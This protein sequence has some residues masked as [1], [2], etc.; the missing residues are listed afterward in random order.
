MLSRGKGKS[1]SVG[2]SACA[3]ASTMQVQLLLKRYSRTRTASLVR[4]LD[5][6][7]NSNGSEVF[8][9]DEALATKRSGATLVGRSCGAIH[10]EARSN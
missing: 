6:S 9:A 7:S 8:S 3:S 4:G 1:K 5:S 2:A 10:V